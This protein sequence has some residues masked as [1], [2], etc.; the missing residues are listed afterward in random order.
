MEDFYTIIYMFTLVPF[1]TVTLLVPA[2]V[3]FKIKKVAGVISA[4]MF[5]VLSWMMTFLC[6][7]AISFVNIQIKSPIWIHYK[8]YAISGLIFLFVAYAIYTHEAYAKRHRKGISTLKSGWVGSKLAYG[9]GVANDIEIEIKDLPLKENIKT[10]KRKL[11]DNQSYELMEFLQDKIT[12]SNYMAIVSKNG[13]EYEIE[14]ES[15]QPYRFRITVKDGYESSYKGKL[16][17]QVFFSDILDAIIDAYK[18]NKIK[19]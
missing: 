3:F 1:C 14:T 17:Y 8:I 5:S 9:R 10:G 19:A 11:Y 7:L 2:M 6:Y 4:T 18:N 15:V 16:N 13:A 12:E